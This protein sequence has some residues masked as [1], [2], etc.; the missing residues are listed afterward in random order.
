MGHV[1]GAHALGL[2]KS[3]GR[4]RLRPLLPALLIIMDAAEGVR[5]RRSR[6]ESEKPHSA[7]YITYASTKPSL[8]CRK[9]PASRPAIS[10]PYRCH[11]RTARSF[12][13]T[14]MLN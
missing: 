10:N 13:L 5:V 11:S 4:G 9:A 12:V 2:R 6:T 8:G 7:R 1:P 3:C 14:T